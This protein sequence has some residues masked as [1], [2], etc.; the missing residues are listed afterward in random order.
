MAPKMPSTETDSR[1]TGLRLAALTF[2]PSS[3]SR[4][5]AARGL[6]AEVT[7]VAT[8]VAQMPCMMHND[9]ARGAQE[10]RRGGAGHFVYEPMEAKCEDCS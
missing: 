6:F 9:A 1:R 8:P 5:S 3:L 10:G 4:P 2:S 7:T